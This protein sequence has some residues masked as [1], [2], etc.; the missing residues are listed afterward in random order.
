MSQVKDLVFDFGNLLFNLLLL[1]LISCNALLDSKRLALSH[2]LFDLEEST[3]TTE[4]SERKFNVYNLLR[5]DELRICVDLLFVLNHFH[6]V[7]SQG[8]L[9]L[10]N[11][12]Q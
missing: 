4:R 10:V 6:Q 9:E 3:V 2:F 1:V 12:V 7:K 8:L 5:L 11:F